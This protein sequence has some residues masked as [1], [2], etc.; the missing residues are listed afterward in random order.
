MNS[1]NTIK[2]ASAFCLAL[3]IT[4]GS[5]AQVPATPSTKT[6]PK[7]KTT[8]VTPAT[9]TGS[10]TTPTGKTTTPPS[11]TVT[12]APTP[13]TTTPAPTPTPATGSTTTGNEL[14][15]VKQT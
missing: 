1:K 6:G 3:S 9:N 2:I 11:K 14:K 15:L 10:T 12:P 7:T 4:L 5:Y 13:A 8:T